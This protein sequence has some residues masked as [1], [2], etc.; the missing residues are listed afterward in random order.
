M[1]RVGGVT[2]VMLVSKLATANR[3]GNERQ[4]NKQKLFGFFVIPVEKNTRVLATKR[5]QSRRINIDL[6]L[7]KVPV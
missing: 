4:T 6:Y 5:F 2:M 7:R 3:K 1:E